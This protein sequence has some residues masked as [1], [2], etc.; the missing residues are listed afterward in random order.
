[1]TALIKRKYKKKKK[2]TRIPRKV[3]ELL[4]D[5]LSLNLKKYVASNSSSFFGDTSLQKTGFS[6]V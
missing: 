3:L 5:L 6:L 4:E 1:M 2:T